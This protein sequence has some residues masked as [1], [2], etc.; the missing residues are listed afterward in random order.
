VYATSNISIIL[1]DINLV[2]YPR[3]TYNNIYYTDCNKV[4]CIT[5][6]GSNVFTFCSPDLKCADGIDTDR[7]RNVYVVGRTSNNILRL[8]PGGQNSDIIMKK[9]VGIIDPLTLCFSRDFKK[10]FV[11]NKSGTQVVVYN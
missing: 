6:D 9:E 8:S 2:V 3:N 1:N 11:S 4:S 7:Q 5:K 10:L